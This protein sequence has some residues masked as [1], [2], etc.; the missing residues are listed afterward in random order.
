[1]LSLFAVD[2]ALLSSRKR[3]QVIYMVQDLCAVHSM[4]RTATAS[5]EASEFRVASCQSIGGDHRSRQCAT[6]G[7]FAVARAAAHLGVPAPAMMDY[8]LM[9]LILICRPCCCLRGNK[10]V[11]LQVASCRT[12]NRKCKVES[13]T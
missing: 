6:S 1:M 13:G 5:L 12:V 9:A 4:W 2:Y 11:E 10:A 8:S 7:F 3:R